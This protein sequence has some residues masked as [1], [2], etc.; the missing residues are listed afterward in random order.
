MNEG[1]RISCEWRLQNARYGTISGG[2]RGSICPEGHLQFPPREICP[3]CAA[4]GY[5]GLR[6]FDEKPGTVEIKQFEPLFYRQRRLLP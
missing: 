5:H 2:L 4:I 3:E 6:Q 1:W